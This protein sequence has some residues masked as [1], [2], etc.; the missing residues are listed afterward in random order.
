MLRN[1][2]IRGGALSLIIQLQFVLVQLVTGIILARLLGPEAFGIYSFSLAVMLLIQIMPN[3]GLDNVVL[4]YSAQYYAGQ[5]WG[6]LR[7][8]WRSA[9]FASVTYGVVSAAVLATVS[10]SGW[11]PVTSALDPRALAAA[12]FPMLFVPLI[13][14]VGA[15]TRSIRHGVIGQF[16]Q[17]LVKPWAYLFLVLAIALV[18]PRAMSAE[19]ALYAQGAA[20]VVTVLV[21]FRWLTKWRPRE[22][23]CCQ[24]EYEIRPWIRAIM[25]LSI[26]AGLMLINTQADILMLGILG[27]AHGTGL[28]RVAAQGANLVALSLTAANV[29]IAPRIASMFS[30]G[31]ISELQRLLTITSITT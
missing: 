17:F 16:P 11:L 24:P 23:A 9:L 6:M 1:G 29:Y 22:I 2:L 3:S 15:S 31:K 8:L 26:T 30:Q 27:T 14:F 4:R 5:R 18:A 13:T 12:T 7:G 21:G 20:A 25:P 10:A 28:Y 19:T